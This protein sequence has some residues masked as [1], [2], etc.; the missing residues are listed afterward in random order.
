MLIQKSIPHTN[1]IVSLLSIC[2]NAKISFIMLTD[3]IELEREILKDLLRHVL[4]G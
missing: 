2:Y 1:N 3:S 4:R